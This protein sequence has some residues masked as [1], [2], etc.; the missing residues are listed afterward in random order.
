MWAKM[1]AIVLPVLGLLAIMTRESWLGEVKY[2]WMKFKHHLPVI[3]TISKLARQP[4]AV[5]PGTKALWTSPETQLTTEYHTFY[6]NHEDDPDLYYKATDYL[7]KVNESGSKPM[8]MWL[9][10]LTVGLVFIEAIG[11]G[12]ALA[13]YAVVNVIASQVA[14]VATVGAILMAVVSCGLAH[15]AGEESAYNGKM[16]TL[17]TLWEK[18]NTSNKGSLVQSKPIA[19]VNTYDDDNVPDE[20]YWKQICRRIEIKGGEALPKF[21]W[22]IA[23]LL[24]VIAFGALAFYLRY[25]ALNANMTEIA[26][27]AG[28]NTGSSSTAGLFDATPGAS[29]AANAEASQGAEEQ[30]SAMKQAFYTTFIIFSI[31]YVC[32]QAIMYALTAKYTMVGQYSHKAWKYTHRFASADQL[33]RELDRIRTRINGDAEKAL[34]KLRNRLRG[35][36]H[37]K[38]EQDAM[39]SAACSRKTF[40][41]FCEHKAELDHRDHLNKANRRADKL[42]V[43]RQQKANRSAAVA[44]PLSVVASNTPEVEIEDDVSSEADK[45]LVLKEIMN[46]QQLA[47][48][49]PNELEDSVEDLQEEFEAP[50]LTLEDL[51]RLQSKQVSRRK[52]SGAN[53]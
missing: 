33:D 30:I 31:V 25:S 37:T 48:L 46:T 9:L 42:Q 52:R 20:S 44:A 6:K 32:V 7:E 2:M 4:I 35:K 39:E 21:G 16:K 3:G 40:L 49:T 17:R 27:S 15:L 53:A 43:E 50:W 11:F 1:L 26:Q 28:I 45:Q 51:E 23:L 47:D 22:H 12:F 5:D 18:D 24:I 13:P 19:L 29:A 14:L 10:L 8:P 34:N 36:A 38:L 41:T